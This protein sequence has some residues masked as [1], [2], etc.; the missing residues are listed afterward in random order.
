MSIMLK[1]IAK[2]GKKSDAP[3]IG[4]YFIVISNSKYYIYAANPS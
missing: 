4:V 3:Y 1:T 2:I